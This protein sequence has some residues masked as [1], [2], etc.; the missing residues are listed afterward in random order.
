MK[1]S[2]PTI[3]KTKL[4]KIFTMQVRENPE[5]P[6]R[7]ITD[8]WDIR[9]P[10]LKGF[11]NNYSYIVTLREK[12]SI[13]GNHYHENQQELIYPIIGTFTVA[14]ENVESREKERILV[15]AAKHQVIYFPAKIAHAI[16]AETE[17]AIFLVVTT[18]TETEVIP[19]KVL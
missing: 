17:K 15:E 6:G 19:Y 16:R 12:G 1:S 11:E 9:N 18:S 14:L 8:V 13:A 3:N 4:S 2:T 7:S 5:K 10:L